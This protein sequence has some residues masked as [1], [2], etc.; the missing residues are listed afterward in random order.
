MKV[1]AC[2]ALEALLAF[3]PK[4]D[5]L[6]HEDAAIQLG[7]LLLSQFHERDYPNQEKH[8]RFGEV[9]L[10]LFDLMSEH[11]GDSILFA[12]NFAIYAGLEFSDFFNMDFNNEQ[13]LTH[14]LFKI[15]DQSYQKT[16]KGNELRD[17]NEML[18]QRLAQYE[19]LSGEDDLEVIK[20]FSKQLIF[21]NQNCAQNN[22]LKSSEE[23]KDQN[24]S[25]LFKL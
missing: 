19:K 6:Y 8:E 12:Q 18:K 20:D 14:L 17:E 16:Q 2:E 1:Q 5:T 15:A 9:V 22:S 4:Q 11:E 24:E 23:V 7:N 10:K 21:T 25:N 3:A 13:E